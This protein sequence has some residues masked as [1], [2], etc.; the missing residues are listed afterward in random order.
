M[1]K[2]IESAR[3][4][5]HNMGYVIPLHEPLF[6]DG[7]CVG[8]SC[9]EWKRAHGQPGYICNT[10][11]K[12]PRHNN[13]EEVA[14]D[15]KEQIDRWWQAW[16]TANIGIAAGKSGLVCLDA[17]KYK[18]GGDWVNDWAETVTSLTGGGGEHLIYL[19]PDGPPLGGSS[20]G[21]P[22]FVD[23]RAHGGQFVAPPSM[24]PSGR[25]YEWEE[26]YKPN[27]LSPAMLPEPIT[28]VLRQALDGAAH[29]IAAPEAINLDDWAD[30]LPALVMAL[31][32]NDRS[33]ID[34]WLIRPLVAAGLTD[35]QIMTLWD[36]YDPNGKY[37]EKGKAAADYLART[38]ASARKHL[39]KT[40]KPARQYQQQAQKRY[41][42]RA[43]I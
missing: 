19:H 14:S 27:Q 24:H 41:D 7:L 38:I 18:A 26:G 2:Y 8:C 32:A 39:E 31:L 5:A 28:A 29:Q 11:G 37:S 12:H 33:K 6:A 17:D 10:P 21:L 3:W 23:V 34:F 30:R 4:Y 9:E 36:R 20:K 35:G 43:V 42:L 16:P 1:A 13:W 40:P 22:P 25:R 15:S